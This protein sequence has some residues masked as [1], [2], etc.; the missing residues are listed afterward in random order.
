MLLGNSSEAVC[1]NC[2]SETVNPAG[3]EAAGT[4]RLLADSLESME[5]QAAALVQEAERKGM[6]ISA[7]K[8]ALRDVRQ[9]RIES[10]TVVH[11]FDS[12]RY[13]E[14]ARKGIISAHAVRDEARAAVGEFYFR[15]TGLGVATLIITVLAV[16][17]FLVIRRIE[18]RQ[19][20]KDEESNNLLSKIH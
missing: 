5:S 2:H 10:R 20:L 19:H 13:Q 14:V 15:R 8:F 3:F 6:E 1:S 18:R 11:A 9:V 12:L 17:L 16:S 4:M 7:A